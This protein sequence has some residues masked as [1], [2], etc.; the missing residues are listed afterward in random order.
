MS[1]EPER[2]S[3]LF[4]VVQKLQV[5][6]LRGLIW[7]IGPNRIRD[8]TFDNKQVYSLFALGSSFIFHIHLGSFDFFEVRRS[9]T[10]MSFPVTFQTESIQ[11]FQT[12][13]IQG[14]YWKKKWHGKD[15]QDC[16]NECSS[17]LVNRWVHLTGVTRTTL[18]LL[19][20]VSDDG[21]PSFSLIKPFVYLLYIC[22]H[23]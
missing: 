17:N 16:P 3:V 22:I 23:Y 9:S 6:R 5:I 13:S 2:L 20:E 4:K 11:G 7:T 10:V 8:Y 12:E 15:E 21:C 14:P 19:L 18:I 1:R